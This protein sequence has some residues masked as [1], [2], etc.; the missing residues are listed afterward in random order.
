MFEIEHL[1]TPPWM[2]FFS[3]PFDDEFLAEGANGVE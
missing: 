3:I 2:L 1:S